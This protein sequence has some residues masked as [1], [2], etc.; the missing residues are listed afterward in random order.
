MHHAYIYTYPI[1]TLTYSDNIID[2]LLQ[3]ANGVAGPAGAPG[4]AAE[5]GDPGPQGPQ[6]QRGEPV[7]NTFI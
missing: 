1:H 3:G 4:D 6:G 2:A 5:A 7:S